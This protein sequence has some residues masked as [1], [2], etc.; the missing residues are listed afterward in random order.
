MKKFL[1]PLFLA[2]ALIIPTAIVE[3][4]DVPS[5]SRVAGNYVPFKLREENNLCVFTATTAVL[6]CVKILPN[7]L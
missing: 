1:L 2:F 7:N 4:A 3:A 6:T 5:F